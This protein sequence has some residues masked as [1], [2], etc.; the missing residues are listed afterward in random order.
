MNKL[1][2]ERLGL[3]DRRKGESEKG[4]L[5]LHLCSVTDIP[6]DDITFDRAYHVNC[7]YYWPDMDEAVKELH[8]VMKPGGLMISTLNIEDLRRGKRRG[9]IR[10]G[11]IDPERYIDSLRKYGFVN[12]IMENVE[13]DNNGPL[14][15]ITATKQY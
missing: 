1:A 7:Y 4:K 3:D 11:D 9:L 6:Y 5:K 10:Y 13:T 2:R 15:A 14:Q 12:V 8:R